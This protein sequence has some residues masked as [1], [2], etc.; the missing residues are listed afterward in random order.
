MEVENY[1]KSGIA[2]DGYCRGNPGDGGYIG[3]DL[4]TGDI[5]FRA[6][7]GVCTNNIAE[8]IG[9]C[10]ALGYAKQENKLRG[11]NYYRIYTDSK[12]AISWLEKKQVNSSFQAKGELKEKIQRCIIWIV[13]EKS[14]PSVLKWETHLW[15]EIPADA[16]HKK[17]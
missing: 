11:K 10:H 14:L 4:E 16:G 12:T 8:F 7:L 3:I 13:Q 6:K 17:K 9:L 2:V 5:L 15:G 1:P